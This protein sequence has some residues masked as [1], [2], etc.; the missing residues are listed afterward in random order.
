MVGHKQLVHIKGILV[1]RAKTVFPMGPTAPQLGKGFKP[2][3]KFEMGMEQQSVKEPY[4]VLTAFI[5]ELLID[6][7]LC[8]TSPTS[9]KDQLIFFR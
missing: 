3:T 8:L 4:V 2:V 1:D 6:K 7:G 5:P 9:S